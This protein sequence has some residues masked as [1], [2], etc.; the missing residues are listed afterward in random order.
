[1]PEMQQSFGA[2]QALVDTAEAA[3]LAL[4]DRYSELCGA[5]QENSGPS[6]SGDVRRIHRAG[7]QCLDLAWQAVDLMLRTGGSSSAS[8]HAALGRYFR[9]LAVIRTHMGLQY[10]HV[11]MNVARLHFGLPP[12]SPL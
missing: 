1:M 4:A 5:A 8:R 2:A 7:L 12:L 9:G 3:I 10:D 6:P 11:S